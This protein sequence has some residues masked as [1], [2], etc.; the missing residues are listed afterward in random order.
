MLTLPVVAAMAT[1]SYYIQRAVY[2][3]QAHPDRHVPSAD[4]GASPVAI[5]HADPAE[6]DL[7]L[8]GVQT[9]HRIIEESWVD[10]A[11]EQVSA[12]TPPSRA[13]VETIGAAVVVEGLV[14]CVIAALVAATRWYLGRIRDAYWDSSLAIVRDGYGGR[15]RGTGYGRK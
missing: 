7:P 13:A 12:P 14:L 6:R 5:G 2:T 9:A 8:P 15:S 3:E 11:G 1:E 10:K 4:A